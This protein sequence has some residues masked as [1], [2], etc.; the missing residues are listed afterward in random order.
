MLVLS[1]WKERKVGVWLAMGI[2]DFCLG[3]GFVLIEIAVGAC[4][5]FEM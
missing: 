1:H 4:R 2:F 5:I 3:I